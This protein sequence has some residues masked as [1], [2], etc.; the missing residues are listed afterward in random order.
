MC[1]YCEENFDGY[2]RTLDKNGHVCIFDEPSKKILNIDW[3][4][5]NMNININYCPKCGRKLREEK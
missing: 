2:Y 4:G 1:R 5:H 3:Y